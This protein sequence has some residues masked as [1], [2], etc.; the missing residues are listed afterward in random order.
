MPDLGGLG[1]EIEAFEVGDAQLGH[2]EHD[3]RQIRAVD[4]LHREER[5]VLE[6]VAAEKTIA[7]ARRGPARPALSLVAGRLGDGYLHEAGGIGPGI[8]EIE[9]GLA[10]IDDAGDAVDRDAGLGDVR[11]ND[12]FVLAE[13]RLVENA[14]LL[15]L[16]EPG[17]QRHD[18]GCDRRA[19]A[20][21]EPLHAVLDGPLAGQ[22]DED[23]AVPALRRRCGTIVRSS[24]R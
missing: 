14:L 12:D 22:E 7:G 2:S 9:L 24:C 19:L 20:D 4:L 8:V 11:R 15:V 18:D 3:L 6:I 13:G 16:A 23:V 17:V 5:S 10:G 21:R 1:N